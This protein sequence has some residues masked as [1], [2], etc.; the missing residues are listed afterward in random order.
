MLV[1]T[2][3]L[4]LP[5]Q[6]T[7]G[8]RVSSVGSDQVRMHATAH[9]V[10]SQAAY[11]VHLITLPS[12]TV[13]REYVRAD[14]MVFGVGWEGPTLPNLKATLGEAF[15]KYVAA[16]ATRR[17]TPLAVSSDALVVVSAGHLRAFA[18]YAYLPQAVPTG[19]DASA[20]Q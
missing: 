10:T 8:E 14:G 6:A 7:L 13:V 19:V 16:I 9:S 11:T 4:S 3:A 2:C 5:A 12:G 20:I 15:D 17:A 18:G 1:A